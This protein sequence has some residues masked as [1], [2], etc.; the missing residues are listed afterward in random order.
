MSQVTLNEDPHAIA[1]LKDD[2]V[3]RHIPRII[4]T[5]CSMFLRKGGV[6]K[7]IVTGSRRYSYD[8]AQ[9]GM[10]IPCK[11]TFSGE[12]RNMKMLRL[13]LILKC[14]QEL[15]FTLTRKMVVLIMLVF[16]MLRR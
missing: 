1:I 14:V 4:S 2:I 9:E 3:V 5:I 8:L 13:L 7:C 16:H 6:I 15:L 12:E 11:F 10:E